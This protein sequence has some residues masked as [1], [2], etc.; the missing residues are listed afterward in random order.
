MLK[1]TIFLGLTL[2]VFSACCFHRI[3][4][5][6][7]DRSTLE[8]KIAAYEKAIS[9][10]CVYSEKGALLRAIA[11]HGYPAA[12]AM[13]ERLIRPHPSFPLNDAINVLEHV[14]FQGSDLR[15]HE[16]MRVLK[17]I[18]ETAAN[19]AVRAEA[20]KAIQ[21]IRSN[22]PLLGVERLSVPRDP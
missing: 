14:H 11:S 18:S 10:R 12:D 20:E 4:L 17:Q 8:Q 1:L 13:I 7:F 9:E 21:R 3:D 15:D 19:A 16:A 22:N 5:D 2:G 6:A